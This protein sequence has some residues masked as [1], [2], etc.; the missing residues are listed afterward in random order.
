L[1]TFTNGLVNNKD[2]TD[3]ELFVFDGGLIE[4]TNKYGKWSMHMFLTDGK[5]SVKI[6]KFND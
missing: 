2:T 6:E 1:T 3:A 5:L 4:Y